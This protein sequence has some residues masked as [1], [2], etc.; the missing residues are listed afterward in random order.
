MVVLIRSNEVNP[1]P[2]LQKYIDYLE[3]KNEN[4]KIIGWNRSGKPI[5]KK[6]HIY[7]ELK[8]NYGDGYKNILK[9][10]KWFI[11]IFKWL[12]KNKKIYSLVHSCD[13]DTAIPAYFSKI[14]TK[15]KMIFDVFDVTSDED[16]KNLLN[17]LIINLEKKIAT[18]SDY[19]II[20]E[21]E[22]KKQIDISRN[23]ILVMPNIPNLNIKEDL[24]IKE[25]VRVQNKPYKISLSYVGVFDRHRGIEDILDIV[26]KDENIVLHMAGFGYLD[27]LVKE[28]SEKFSNIIYWGRVEYNVG[29]NIMAN[30]DLII[31]N[32]YLSNPLHRL[33]APNKYYEGLMLGKPII[34]T[35]G[36]LVGEKTLKYNTGFAISDNKDDLIELLQDLDLKRSIDEKGENCKN[37]WE[38][39]Y[40]ECIDNFMENSYKDIIERSKNEDTFC[41]R[42]GYKI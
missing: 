22:R 24:K 37:L 11:Y 18:S 35:K 13:L 12:I 28:F 1:D 2:R 26:S 32:Y 20:C 3:S 6:K 17:T 39:K 9:K 33:A 36:T 16:K 8:A 27:N 10:I 14:F 23:D 40:S 7:F 42:T 29:L 25:K 34:T 15:K 19:L 21:E 38:V 5:C 30:S 31:A 4:Y 41:C